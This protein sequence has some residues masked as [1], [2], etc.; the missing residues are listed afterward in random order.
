M[1]RRNY[2]RRDL[3]A[4]GALGAATWLSGCSVLRPGGIQLGAVAVTNQ[5]TESRAVRVRVE[6]DGQVVHESTVSL[7]TETGTDFALVECTWDSTTRGVFRFESE[8]VGTGETNVTTSDRLEQGRCYVA[9]VICFRGTLTSAW[10]ECV[11]VEAY[12]EPLCYE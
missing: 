6:R 3:L 12:P 4:T 10:D 1:A 5:S 7:G 8:L 2:S 9:D 11:E